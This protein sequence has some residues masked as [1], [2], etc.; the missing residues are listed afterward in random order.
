MREVSVALQHGQTDRQHLMNHVCWQQD[1]GGNYSCMTDS[2][3][4]SS[5]AT[6]ADHW[7]L[8]WR[9]CVGPTVLWASVV[10]MLLLLSLTGLVWGGGGQ[11]HE[12][13]VSPQSVQANQ[14][15]ASTGVP[16]GESLCL[17]LCLEL[18]AGD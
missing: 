14:D 17:N 13:A 5:T 12:T 9:R 16:A 10:G 6:E 18:F 7:Q 2:G 8:S 11:C 3:Q 4:L 1:K 15:A